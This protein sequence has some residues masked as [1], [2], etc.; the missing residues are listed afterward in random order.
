MAQK[1]YRW[2]SPYEWLMEKAESWTREQLFSAL[3]NVAVN[4]DSDTLQ[5]I[6]EAEMTDDGYFR[7]LGETQDE[8][9]Q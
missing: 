7:R 6:F 4:T 3:E 9:D 5:D 8:E 2:D 1:Q